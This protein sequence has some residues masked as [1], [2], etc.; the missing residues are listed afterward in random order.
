MTA[1]ATAALAPAAAAEPHARKDHWAYRLLVRPRVPPVQD[2]TRRSN[3]IDAFVLAKLESQGMKPSPEADRRT[4]IRRV[5]FDLTGLPP[6]PADVETF[7]TDASPGAYE[8]L[9]DRLLA[10]PRYG[11]RWARHWM[12][13]VHYAETHGHDE[14]KPRP[15]AWSYR[16]YLIRSFNEDDSYSRFVVEQIAGDVLWPDEPRATVA[17][18]FLAVGPWDQSSQMGIEDGTLD[19][20][21]ARYLDRDDMIATAM[22]TFVSSTVHCAR[23]HAHKFDP[24]SQEDY[25]ALQAVFAGV[26]RVDRSYDADPKVHAERKRLNREKQEL[27]GSGKTERLLSP[28]VQAQVAAWEKRVGTPAAW[29]V[30]EPTEVRSAEGATLT[31]LE[32]GSILS[33][34]KR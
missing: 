21:V 33:G 10:S 27:A 29:S 11:E 16:D 18:A 6:T 3:P 17:T 28:E 24:I 32:D 4:L 30:L 13:V 22:S 12:D 31:E 25:Y 8:R 9:V 7:L 34:G 14:D 15:N 19:K 5:Y 23:C 1:W 26:D 20:Q 2:A